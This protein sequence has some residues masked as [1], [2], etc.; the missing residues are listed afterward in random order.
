MGGGGHHTFVVFVNLTESNVQSE[1]RK[2]Q[3]EDSVESHTVLGVGCYRVWVW[4][5]LEPNRGWT[6][7]ESKYG[8]NCVMA[9]AKY[10]S[11]YE[12]RNEM[13]NIVYYN[14]IHYSTRQDA[15]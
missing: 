3:C 14:L 7:T 13:Y 2:E 4:V 11:N 6:V 15:I 10:A 9:G 5:R 8:R 12:M 1:D